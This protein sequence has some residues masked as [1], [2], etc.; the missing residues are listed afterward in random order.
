MSRASSPNV[1]R[2]P[3][4][5]PPAARR[6]RLALATWIGVLG[7]ALLGLVRAGEVLPA[8]PDPRRPGATPHWIDQHGALTSAFVVLRA[9]A[10]VVATYLAVV[11]VLGVLA[12]L[13]RRAA[14][15]RLADAVTVA[16]L[17]HLLRATTAAGALTLPVLAGG[18]PTAA[19]AA[20]DPAPTP[21]PTIRVLTTEPTTPPTTVPTRLP[22]IDPPVLRR[23]PDP[24][25]V[26]EPAG[27]PTEA[28]VTST[29]P[30]S[31]PTPDPPT[32]GN[33]RSASP[34]APV[35]GGPAP[36]TAPPSSADEP[37]IAGPAPDAPA[38]G[39]QVVDLAP[40]PSGEA[41]TTASEP[42]PE[43][44]WRIEAGDHLWRVA[45]QTLRAHAGTPPND[46]AVAAYLARLVEAN[47]DQLVVPDNPDLVFAGQVFL[48]PPVAP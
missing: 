28:P 13:T 41:G 47:R 38:P 2:A 22:G 19:W 31:D 5:R 37:P 7:V 1:R 45:E 21:P 20:G 48:L 17:R 34:A 12:R 4:G 29:L 24:V 40:G 30:T 46:D 16:R 36:G 35:D 8:L 15:V 39:E 9:I 6:A 10:I 43:G 26:T 11:T 18:G 33:D 42:P 27:T 32:A 23:L 44:T 25:P 14:L 3:G